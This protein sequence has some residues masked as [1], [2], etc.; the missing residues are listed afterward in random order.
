MQTKTTRAIFRCEFCGSK[1]SKRSSWLRHEKLRSD[2][3][4]CE[5]PVCNSSYLGNSELTH[6]LSPSGTS[7]AES[8]LPKSTDYLRKQAL[9][10]YYKTQELYY[11]GD[12]FDPPDWNADAPEADPTAAVVDDS[13]RSVTA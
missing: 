6:I 11:C 7:D 3:Y 12:L 10:E 8:A 9:K 1:L 13:D 5:N 4:C 2:V